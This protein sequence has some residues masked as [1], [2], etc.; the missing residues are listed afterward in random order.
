MIELNA[1]T[2]SQLGP[3]VRVPGYDRNRLRGGIVH[4]GV[5]NFHRIHQAYYIDAC[6]H[7][8]GNEGWGIVGI[9]LL[10][11]PSSRAKAEAYKAQDNLYTI[12]E[13][14]LDGTGRPRV[15][16]A[17]I[18]YLHAPADPEAVLARLASPDTKIVT[19]TITEG[20]YNIDEATGRFMLESA[21][22]RHRPRGRCTQD[23]VRFHRGGSRSSS[24]RGFAGLHGRIM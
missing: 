13:Y 23:R 14:A 18:E 17:M 19:L 21:G 9:G 20:G 8:P 6:L 11:G 2:L 1:S 7:Q 16:G 24:R 5:G 4:F 22:C 10:D 3:K 15:I 12:T